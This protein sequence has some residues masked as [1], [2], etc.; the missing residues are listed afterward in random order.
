MLPSSGSGYRLT[1]FVTGA[2]ARSASALTNVRAFCERELDNY[3]LEIVDLYRTPE[4][5]RTDQVVAAPT[6]VRYDPPP[7]RRIIGNMSDRHRM[8]QVI[9]V[10]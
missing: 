4:R 3:R 8:K 10:E 6:L 9:K 1:L 5:A 2:T 7:A